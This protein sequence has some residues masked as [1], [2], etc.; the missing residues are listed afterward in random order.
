[1]GIIDNV[2]SV[3][4]TV[5]Q[6]DNID[7]YTRILDLQGEILSLVEE[8]TG[9]RRQVT[10]LESAAAIAAVLV[11]RRDSYWRTVGGKDDGPFC[12]RCWD[13]DKQLVRLHEAANP[14]YGHCPNCDKA[15]KIERGSMRR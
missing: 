5:Q 13:V 6:I 7:L 3:A 15:G 8:N 2:K 11:V 10:D 4:R 1:M 9:L 14:E 12:T